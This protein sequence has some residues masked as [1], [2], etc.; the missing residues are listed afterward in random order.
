MKKL[1]ISTALVLVA[2][3]SFGQENSFKKYM[4]VRVGISDL[5]GFM[6]YN[7]NVNGIYN[8][9]LNYRF[10]KYFGAGIQ[11]GYG[12]LKTNAYAT[13]GEDIHYGNLFR[14]A[15]SGTFYISPLFL[16]KENPKFDL[17]IRGVVGGQTAF[18]KEPYPNPGTYNRF[19][20]G[21]YVGFNYSPFKNIGIYGEVGYGNRSHSQFGISYKFRK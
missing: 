10:S 13:G 15:A 12:G 18:V 2:L 7:N 9:N 14:Y 8:L 11:G 3:F 20:Y 21:G 19:D 16:K 1:T 5:G 17:Y 4:E 6:D